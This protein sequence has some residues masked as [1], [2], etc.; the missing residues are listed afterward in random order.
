MKEQNTHCGLHLALQRRGPFRCGFPLAAGILAMWL[1]VGGARGDTT[2]ITLYSFTGGD[3]G[4]S[5]YAGLVQGADGSFYGTTWNGGTN[6]LG[7]VFQ[8]T[9]ASAFVSLFSFAKTN[10]AHPWAGLIQG[11]NGYLYGTTQNWGT[12]GNNGTIFSLTTN[13]TVFNPL[14]S[15][16]GNNGQEP[17]GALVQGS[18]GNFYGTTQIGSPSDLG[19]VFKLTASGTLN[20][21]ILFNSTTTNGS[22]PYDAL[23]QGKDGG[24]YGTTSLGGANSEGTVFRVTTQGGFTNLHVFTA[25]NSGTNIDGAVPYA[26]LVQGRDGNFYGTTAN[27]GTNGNGTIFKI[28]TNGTFTCLYSF[29][30]LDPNTSTNTD[31][32]NP[33][34]G[35]VQGR[36][37]NFYGTTLNG[38]TSDNGT[39]F[40]ITP[41]G[42]L[43]SLY[44][45]S[46]LDDGAN[47]YAGLVEGTDGSFYGTTSTGGQSDGSG[48]GTVFQLVFPAIQSV[49]AAGNTLT[50]TWSAVTGLTYQV[51]FSTN[52]VKTDWNYLG[53][54]F[55]ATN[56]SITTTDSV[57]IDAQRF[58]RVILLP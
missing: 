49:N 57:T 32:A 40:Q 56:T 2:L 23:V 15:F 6:N 10:G 11:T 1:V 14:V 13:G 52:L 43:T 42:T 36:D 33:R 45:F 26:G 3:D 39:I 5:P 24:L 38:G 34:G 35:L 53:G 54:S 9:S 20:P 7:T 18:D 48:A 46:G 4:G 8:I 25:I 58:Y 51:Q 31:G 47:P 28:T 21:L 27:A 22:Q 16:A 17:S 41:T 30:A 50:F 44:S 19:T 29:T 55:T 12:N 37:G